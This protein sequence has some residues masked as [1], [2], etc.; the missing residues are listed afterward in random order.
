MRLDELT[1]QCGE[2]L[3]GSGPESDIVIS[4]RIRLAHN[5]A[6]FPFI[7]K[8]TDQDRTAIEQSVRE[9]LLSPERLKDV[10]Y[11]DVN[12]LETVD[13]QFLVE[14]QLIS[15]EHAEGVGTARWPSTR[16]RSSA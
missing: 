13:R 3:R 14:R 6:E 5:L 8:C 1:R 12:R 2:W 16:P 4:S 10:L 11:L 7:R 15:R 9:R